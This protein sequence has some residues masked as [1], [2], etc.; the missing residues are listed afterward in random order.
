[1]LSTASYS[2]RGTIPEKLGSN[3]GEADERDAAG[4][5]GW[6]VA[7][8]ERKKTTGSTQHLHT[9]GVYRTISIRLQKEFILP[10]ALARRR[11]PPWISQTDKDERETNG[12]GERERG[13]RRA[14]H[15]PQD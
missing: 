3:L 2:S 4:R 10:V 1:M 12:E 5:C 8:E 9:N 11:L 7:K 14:L 6:R 13:R 15:V